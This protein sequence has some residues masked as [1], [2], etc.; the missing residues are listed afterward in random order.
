MRKY[1]CDFWVFY[2]TLFGE[3]RRRWWRWKKPII[4]PA[5]ITGALILVG[6]ILHEYLIER[7]PNYWV[8]ILGQPKSEMW[9]YA[10][11]TLAG[12]GSICL[13]GFVV[14]IL[15]TPAFMYAEAKNLA[16]S[17]TE[18]I[19]A[20]VGITTKGSELDAVL[21]AS[22]E[23]IAALV[24]KIPR[25]L[26]LS[27][28]M[29]LAVTTISQS[30]FKETRDWKSE[31]KSAIRAIVN[32]KI[33][34]LY[35]G[36]LQ[37]DSPELSAREY[38]SALSISLVTTDLR[39]YRDVSN[40]DTNDLSAGEVDALNATNQRL[41]GELDAIRNATNRIHRVLSAIDAHITDAPTGPKFN[42]E[43]AE[44][45]KNATYTL[46][47]GIL[48]EEAI[49]RFRGYPISSK[50]DFQKV[51]TSLKAIAASVQDSDLL[52]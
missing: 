44:E 14:S 32:D 36:R 21:T 9:I 45:W 10:I 49:G 47:E 22:R 29:A 27:N 35:E 42:V 48:K 23:R 37:T 28:P 17:S 11:Y 34:R 20:I 26:T 52:D 3:S 2:G 19:P 5:I 50:Y 15:V 6:A 31:T 16:N 25:P 39:G 8:P 7:W 33:V 38:L 40:A 12:V 13:L 18:S 24:S 51:V 1:L 43:D 4:I 41:Q 46:L 30:A